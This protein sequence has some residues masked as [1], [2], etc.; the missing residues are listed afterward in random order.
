MAIQ[1]INVGV[2]ANDGT[3]DDLREAFI[4]V[5]QNFDDLDLRVAGFTE[6]TAENIGSF[7]QSVYAGQS[8]N[9]FQFKKLAVDPLYADTMNVRVSDDGTIVYFSSTQ[10]FSRFTDGTLS[11]VTPVEQYISLTGSEGALVSVSPAGPTINVDSRISR[12]SSPTLSSDLDVNQR[13]LLNVAQLNDIT[14][15]DLEKVFGFD[16]GTLDN[17]VESIIDYIIKNTAIDFGDEYADGTTVDFGQP[18]NDNFAEGA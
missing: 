3:G 14:A 7:G 15:E 17:V 1:N 11:I 9:T 5:N 18:G 8:G 10:A 16:F 13:K 2:L 12:E 4:K 6:I